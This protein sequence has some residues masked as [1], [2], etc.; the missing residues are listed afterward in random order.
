MPPL[1]GDVP[2]RELDA[3]HGDAPG[4]LRVVE[5]ATKWSFAYDHYR[6]VLEVVAQFARCPEHA[7]GQFLVVWVPLLCRGKDLAEVVNW[8]LYSM[9]FALLWALD[10]QRCTDHLVGCCD[11][12]NHRPPFMGR[13]KDWW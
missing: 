1:V 5:D 6:V 4:S 2:W 12:Q 3:P 7:V 10:N 9:G 8:S 11:V 13:R